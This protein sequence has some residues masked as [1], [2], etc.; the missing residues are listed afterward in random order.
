MKQLFKKYGQLTLLEQAKENCLPDILTV[1]AIT[2]LWFPDDIEKQNRLCAVIRL[3]IH[4]R[5][6]M[7]SNERQDYVGAYESFGF[8][9]IK[10]SD[11]TGEV[12]QIH[13]IDFKKWL[14]NEIEED[15]DAL[16]SNGDLNNWL[17][18]DRKEQREV[19]RKVQ[20]QIDKEDVQK[21]GRL[22]KEKYPDVINTTN[23]KK[24]DELKPFYGK[25]PGKSPVVVDDW[26]EEVGVER[27]SR[28][29]QRNKYKSFIPSLK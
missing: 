18:V 8:I 2:Q 9:L 27:G 25:Y 13:K 14:G 17:D 1:R 10:F 6:L 12:A 22:F 16:P 26:L 11:G 29:R 5:L 28:G 15:W 20:M 23:A 4:D 7:V 21:I 24:S 19:D 3:A